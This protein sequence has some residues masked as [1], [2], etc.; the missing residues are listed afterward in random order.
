MS[1][2]ESGFRLDADGNMGFY[3]NGIFKGI[4]SKISE[5]NFSGD[6]KN[7]NEAP[8][9]LDTYLQSSYHSN[10]SESRPK[11]KFFNLLIYAGYPA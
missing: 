1:P 6:V 9:S 8:L 2:R 10:E 4:N 7:I 5:D 3:F 11:T